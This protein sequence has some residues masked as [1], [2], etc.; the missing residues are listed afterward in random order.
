V[1]VLGVCEQTTRFLQGY[2]YVIGK[3]GIERERERLRI[4]VITS[5]AR[6]QMAKV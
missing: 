1:K 2:R 3:S 6:R 4:V 5:E